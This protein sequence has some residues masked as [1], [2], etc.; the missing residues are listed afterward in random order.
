LK[1]AEQQLKDSKTA[2][3]E[4][5]E[6]Y[7]V[8]VRRMSAE[9]PTIYGNMTADLENAMFIFIAC[10]G[11]LASAEAQ[12]WDTVLPGAGTAAPMR[13]VLLSEAEYQKLSEEQD[14][15]TST[16]AYIT[17]GPS[18]LLAKI[19]FSLNAPVSRL[20]PILEVA[21]GMMFQ[22]GAASY[23]IVSVIG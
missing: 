4:G 2:C 20:N 21:D 14:L 16:L 7:D 13:T 6:R 1:G 5:K 9:L 18:V 15:I 12:V 19:E 10:Q 11:R 3:Q 8:I 23:L 22:L 17:G